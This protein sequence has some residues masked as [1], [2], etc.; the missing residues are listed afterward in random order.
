MRKDV[1]TAAVGMTVAAFRAAFPLGSPGQVALLDPEGR[2]AGLV[3]V[4]DAYASDLAETALIGKI[5]RCTDDALVPSM[6]VQQ[7]LVVFD[8]TESEAL[9]VIDSDA[10]RK[11]IGLLTEAHALKRYLAEVEVRRRELFEE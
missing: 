3:M 6:T 4:A 10:S 5:S 7:A 11:V 9:A 2:Y 8:R 1:R